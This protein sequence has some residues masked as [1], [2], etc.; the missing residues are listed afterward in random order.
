MDLNTKNLPSGVY[1]LCLNTEE[2][3]I[4]ERVVIV[5]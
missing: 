3:K 1:L 4:V 2:K 5:R